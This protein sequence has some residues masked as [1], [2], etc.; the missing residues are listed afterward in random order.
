MVD[1]TR[2]QAAGARLL[3]ARSA[4]AVLACR[5]GD[6][7]GRGAG[8]A[9]RALPVAL[10]YGRSGSVVEAA[11]QGF[12]DPMDHDGVLK[13]RR[14]RLEARAVRGLIRQ[15]RSAGGL[16]TAGRG[17]GHPATGV[18]PGGGVSPGVAHISGHEALDRWCAQGVTPHGRGAAGISRDADAWGGACRFRRAADWGGQGLPQRRGHVTREGA[19]AKTRL[20]RGRRVPPGLTR[21][22]TVGG[23]DVFGTEARPGGPR[24]TRRPARTPWPRAGQRLKAWMQAHRHLPGHA[25]CT[26]LKARLRGHARDDG[27]HGHAGARARVLAWA[28]A[29]ACTWRHRRGGTRRCVRGA[30]VTQ[31]LDAI[32]IARPRLTAGRRRRR[33][34]CADAVRGRESNRGTGGANPARPGR[35]GG[36]R[37]TGVP[38]A[39]VAALPL[40]STKIH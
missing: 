35:C 15:W 16:E 25:F 17:G 23:C 22:V 5:A 9:G 40:M 8:E 38:T 36:R 2:L 20:R 28:T 18:P 39:E 3:T 11:R 37:G 4:P 31:I 21:R 6:R 24:V 19:P 7:P 30:R 26:G 32:P 29:G 12:F 1:A 34:A 10:P 33:V 13:M 27:G 14:W